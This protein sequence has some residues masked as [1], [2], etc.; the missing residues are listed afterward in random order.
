MTAIQY[1]DGVT[2]ERA[3]QLFAVGVMCT[4]EKKQHITEELRPFYSFDYCQNC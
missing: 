2:W 4:E 3:E 1:V